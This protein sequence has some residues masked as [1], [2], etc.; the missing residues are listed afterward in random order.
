MK[1]ADIQELE[2]KLKIKLPKYYV[3]YVLSFPDVLSLIHD[4]YEDSSYSNFYDD[5]EHLVRIN[6]FLSKN[7]IFNKKFCIGDNGGGDFFLVDL[8]N[9]E[10]EKVYCFDHEESVEEHYDDTNGTL[11]WEALDSYQNLEAYKNSILNIFGDE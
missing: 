10:N 7:T 8:A 9:H 11:N 6:L 5:A 3:S 4:K 1:L 2:S